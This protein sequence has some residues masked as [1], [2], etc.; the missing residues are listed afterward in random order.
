MSKKVQSRNRDRAMEI[1]IDNACKQIKTEAQLAAFCSTL[2]T[3]TAN[4]SSFLFDAFIAGWYLC[5]F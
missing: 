5:G 2:Q 1:A 4:I 3:F